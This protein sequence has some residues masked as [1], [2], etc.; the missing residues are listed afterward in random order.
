MVM[1]VAR[2]L[3]AAGSPTR[4][5]VF[6]PAATPVLTAGTTGTHRVE[7]VGIGFVPPLLDTDLYEEARA[8]EEDDGREMA[9]R[10]AAEEGLLSGISSGLN[11]AGAV[12]IA[13]EL[14]AGH[15]VVTVA[16]DTGLKYLGGDLF[17]G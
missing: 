17:E 5:V 9:R 15:T 4:V 10:L 3:A 13:Q 8:I 16:V 1:G 11:V 6:E 14:G 12:G 2:A 7:G